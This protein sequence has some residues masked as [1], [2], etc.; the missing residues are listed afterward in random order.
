MKR[1]NSILFLFLGLSSCVNPGFAQQVIHIPESTKTLHDRWTWALG[2]AKTKGS[3]KDYWIGYSIDRLMGEKSY[4]GS[5]YSDRRRN[6][7]TLGELL[8]GMKQDDRIDDRSTHGFSSMDGNFSFDDEDKPERKVVKEVGILFHMMDTE[9]N[10]ID[11]LKVSNLSLHVDFEDDQPDH[12]IRPDLLLWLGS[13]GHAESVSFLESI[14]ADSKSREVKKRLIMAIGI[15]DDSNNAISFLQKTLQGSEP[16]EVRE[17]AAFWLGQTNSDNARKIL[18]ETAQNDQSRNV[19]EKAIFA[20]SQMKSE[21][22]T[23]A[24]ITIAKSHNDRETRKKAA[25]WLGQKA[26]EKAVGALKELAYKD[27]DTEVQKSALF[28]L[29]QIH[30]GDSVTELIKIAR[31]HPN[32]KIRKQAIFWLGQSEDPKALDALIDIIRK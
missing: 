32:P 8:T 16:S 9:E 6:T 28:A 14:F 27:E 5:F 19:R 4:I 3:G 20:L 24:L 25:F 23:D 13:T 17:E 18:F 12:G 31:T 15:H 10:H 1:K 26:S 29:T 11:E 2:E 22:S 7:P 30:G 21:E